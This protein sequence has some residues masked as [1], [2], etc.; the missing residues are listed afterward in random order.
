ML[1]FVPHFTYESKAV[2]TINLNKHRNNKM[3][4]KLKKAWINQ[5]ASNPN[6]DNFL[7]KL[8]GTNVLY[9]EDSNTIAPTGY[10]A[11]GIGLIILNVPGHTVLT[12]GWLPD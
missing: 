12:A 6:S 2:V 7:H 9:D 1:T 3:S 11:K 8:H 10:K 5:P 4:S